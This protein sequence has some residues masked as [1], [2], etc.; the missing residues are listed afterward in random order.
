[1]F[2]VQ[3]DGPV[4]AVQVF[5]ERMEQGSIVNISSLSSLEWPS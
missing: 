5:A 3:L 4:T 1:V 2:D